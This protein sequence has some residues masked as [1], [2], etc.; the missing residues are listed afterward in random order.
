M[1]DPEKV[2]PFSKNPIIAKFFAQLSWV[3]EIGSGMMNIGKYLPHYTTGGVPEYMDGPVFT[4]IIPLAIKEVTGEVEDNFR[5]KFSE[6]FSVKFS[7][8][9]KQLDR[10]IE[11]V[12]KLSSGRPLTVKKLANEY[13]VSVRTIHEDLRRLEGW[14]IVKF[15]G[16]PKTGKYVLTENGKVFLEEAGGE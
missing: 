8:T 13:K 2:V 7:V 11:M 9:G 15:E 3:E 14:D 5:V 12:M 16:A 4:T 10:M 6:N 1:L